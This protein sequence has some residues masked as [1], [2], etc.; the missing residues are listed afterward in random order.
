MATPGGETTH[1]HAKKGREQDDVGE[2]GQE[3]DRAAE[4]PNA[5]EFEKKNGETDKKEIELRPA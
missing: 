5:G 1:R 2:E 3:N 4:P